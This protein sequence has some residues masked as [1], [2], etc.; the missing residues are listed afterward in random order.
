MMSS[1]L[2]A[3]I[4]LMS[5][6]PCAAIPLMD[7]SQLHEK[8][9]ARKQRRMSLRQALDEAAGGNPPAPSDISTVLLKV[10]TKAEK[11]QLRDDLGAS[12][13]QREEQQQAAARKGAKGRRTK[14]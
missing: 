3:A 2:C 13:G 5:S 4:P 14:R 1:L 10:L 8:A 7:L 12:Y 11:D 6:L 9:P